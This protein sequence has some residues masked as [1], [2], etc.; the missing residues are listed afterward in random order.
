MQKTVVL[1]FTGNAKKHDYDVDL[2]L[3]FN[4]NAFDGTKA[5]VI[6]GSALSG[7]SPFVLDFYRDER[8]TLKI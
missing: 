1:S 7:M 5:N 3:E 4:D 8:T 6:K 2:T